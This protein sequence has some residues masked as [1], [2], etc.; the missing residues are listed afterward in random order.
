[1]ELQYPEAMGQQPL[2]TRVT[3]LSFSLTARTREQRSKET[4]RAGTPLCH[5]AQHLH[6]C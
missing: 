1:M 4:V 2:S 3:E 5:L 6:Q